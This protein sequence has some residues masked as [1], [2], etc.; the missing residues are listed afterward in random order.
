MINPLFLL[1]GI[2]MMLTAAIPVF[3]WRYREL[4]SWRFF[5][6]GAGAWF[7]AI[8]P[9]IAMDL[10]VTSI[11]VNWL[12]GIYAS[13]GIAIVTGAY[14]GL[15][16][17]I[18]ESGF[19]Y[20]IAMKTKLKKAGFE[21]AVAFGLGF[22]CVE[23]FLLGMTSFMYVSTLMAFPQII[24]LMTV[25]QRVA[26]LEQLTMD[27]IT[28]FA[29]VIERAFTIMVHV[30]C[31]VLVIQSLKTG[32]VRY[33]IISFLYKGVLDGM[34]PFLTMTYGVSTVGGIYSIEAF[35]ALMGAAALAGT[36]LLG[37]IFG[38]NARKESKDMKALLFVILVVLVSVAI[39]FAVAQPSTASQLE[40]RTVTFDGFSG[41]YDFI[42]NGSLIGTSEFEYSG[43]ML[44]NGEN[45]FIVE[46]TTNFSTDTYEMYIEGTLY[47]TVDA[48]PVFYNT[49]INKNG[50]AKIIVCEFGDGSVRQTETENND[51]NVYTRPVSSDSFIIAN[52]MIS[53]W[54]LM[55]RAAS[56]EPQNTYITRMYSPNIGMDIVRTLEVSDVEN[57]TVNDEEYEAYVF[58]DQFG[59]LNY[60]TPDGVLL[61]VSNPSLE[62]VISDGHP[63][64][65]G[66]LFR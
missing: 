51:T 10:T 12:S 39:A 20:L 22:G 41:K 53:H 13:L 48:R 30:F 59:N 54:A 38:D 58:R 60:V 29:P 66:F 5:A 8:V 40:R 4:V 28:V 14:I 47:S 24:D 3:W 36:Y 21:Q 6:L 16:T 1:S 7:V 55:F 26:V 43:G 27:S 31:S 52:N 33:F 25:Q 63:E 23:A 45:V 64:G 32:K 37:R 56:L 46:E 61:R 44:Y 19:S 11:L 42:V 65:D 34:L 50:Q 35:I 18:F 9:K 17:G 15:R 62:I 2:G 49:T 57:I